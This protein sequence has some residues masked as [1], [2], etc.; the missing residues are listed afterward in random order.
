[1]STP[2]VSFH[3]TRCVRLVPISGHDAMQQVGTGLRSYL[4]FSYWRFRAS[5]MQSLPLLATSGGG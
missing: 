1:M 2:P 4:A 5:R 3:P